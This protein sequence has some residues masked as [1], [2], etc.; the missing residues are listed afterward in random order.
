M[1]EV[2]FYHMERQGIEQVLPS[3]LMKA[4]ENGHRI[5]VKTRDESEAERLNEILWVFRPDI[6]LPHGTKKDGYDAQQPIYLTSSNDNPNNAD[7]LILAQGAESEISTFKLCCELLDGK[8]PEQ[9]DL[10]RAHWKKY[11]D[12]GHALTYWQQGEKTWEKKQSA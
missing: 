2:R 4:L 3:L 7:M 11:K 1:T 5:L 8:D 12:E 6:F 10:G 9:I